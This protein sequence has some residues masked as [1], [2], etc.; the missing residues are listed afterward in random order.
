MTAR[1]LALVELEVVEAK[2]PDLA[3]GEVEA[4]EEPA[5]EE[6]EGVEP[7]ADQAVVSD[8]LAEPA[9]EDSGWEAAAAVLDSA[10]GDWA[11]EGWED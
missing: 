1:G 6:T 8:S 3:L 5:A 2:A 9:P 11:A 7:A 10:A 4:R